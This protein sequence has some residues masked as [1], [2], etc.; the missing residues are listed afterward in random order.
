MDGDGVVDYSVN[1][2]L[3]S[4]GVRFNDDGTVTLSKNGGS[5][6]ADSAQSFKAVTAA[7]SPLAQQAKSFATS[8]ER[9]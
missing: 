1:A 9:T 8:L 2:D 6:G 4:T 7:A 3:D 5:F